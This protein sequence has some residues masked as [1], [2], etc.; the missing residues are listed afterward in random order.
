MATTE[1]AAERWLGFY[2]TPTKLLVGP[3]KLTSVFSRFPASGQ[4]HPTSDVRYI[5]L[6]TVAYFYKV[7]DSLVLQ[8]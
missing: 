2:T 1:T 3:V 7:V 8:T 5:R 6:K 4:Y